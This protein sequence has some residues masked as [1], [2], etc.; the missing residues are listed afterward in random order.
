MA[1]LNFPTIIPSSVSFG[2]KYNT[3]INVS[4]LSGATQTIEVPGARWVA[5][6]SFDDLEAYEGRVMAAFLAELRGASGRFYLQ[7]HSHTTPRGAGGSGITVTAETS[8]GTTIPTTG[9]G[10]SA[11]NI[12][13]KGDDIELENK[14]L[15]I[16]T[17]DV[18]SDVSGNAT[19]TFE[20]PIRNTITNASA[21]VLTDC[22]AIMLLSEDENRWTTNNPG[23]LTDFSID[24]VEGF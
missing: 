6:L 23:L 8:S 7:D 12:L 10:I 16:I 3:Q 13:R 14:E 2:I 9:W 20:P 5:T 22:E 18:D 4:S 19:L 15:K 11:P 21:V 1:T 24:C 17:L